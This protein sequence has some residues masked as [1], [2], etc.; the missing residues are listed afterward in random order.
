MPLFLPSYTSLVTSPFASTVLIKRLSG[1]TLPSTC[2][3]CGQIQRQKLAGITAWYQR[4]IRR[5]CWH[6][7]FRV[8]PTAA[9][10]EEEPNRYWR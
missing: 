5:Q 4:W 2:E 9:C 10:S 6:R 3:V 7:W 1:D 8:Q